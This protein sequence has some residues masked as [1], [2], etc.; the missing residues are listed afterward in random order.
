[1]RTVVVLSFPVMVEL[2]IL[3]CLYMQLSLPIHILIIGFQLRRHHLLIT[4]Q[5]I[6]VNKHLIVHQLLL[7]H[8][9]L[10]LVNFVHILGCIDELFLFHLF[11]FNIILESFHLN[12]NIK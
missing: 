9:H 1:M 8:G 3:W 11:I 4:L 10:L 2:I 6:L 7:H 12:Y 5:P